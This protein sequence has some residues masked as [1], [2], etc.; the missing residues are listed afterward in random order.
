MHLSKKIK[1]L[2]GYF[3]EV[4]NC[5]KCRKLFNY[6]GYG[7]R[8]CP[9]CAKKDEEN[10][11]K[12]KE[13]LYENPGTVLPIIS[14]ETGVASEVIIRYLR[15]GRIEIAEGSS[16]EIPCERCGK[17]IKSGRFCENCVNS[18]SNELHASITPTKK[19][20]VGKLSERDR[21]HIKE[22]ENNSK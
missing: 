8:V 12:V 6:L 20:N 15:E 2:G 18:L 1:N 22:E 14:K 5:R 17:P 7:P 13:Y 3:M 9:E 21:M 19:Q 16:I 10:F 11:K 4:M